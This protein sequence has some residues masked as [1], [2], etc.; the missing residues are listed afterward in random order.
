MKER[1]SREG[2]VLDPETNSAELQQA[3]RKVF[4]STPEGERI[5]KHIIDVFCKVD[6]VVGPQT[7][8][9]ANYRNGMRDVGLCVKNLVYGDLNKKPTGN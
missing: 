6:H 2:R 8:E 9:M 1:H 3:A 4:L 5:L 7:S